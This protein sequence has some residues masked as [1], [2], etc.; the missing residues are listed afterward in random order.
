MAKAR[1]IPGLE[2]SMPY[3]EAAARTVAVRAREV[4]EHS[5]GVLDTGDIERVHAM[6]VATRRLRAV[7]EI[8]EPCFPRDELRPVLRE[9]KALADALGER[10][11]PDVELLA[12][13][14]FAASVGPDERA[15]V[16]VFIER[17]RAQQLA[18]NVSLAG[19]LE[20]A[21]RNDLHGRLGRLAGLARGRVRQQALEIPPPHPGAPDP[22]PDVVP[23]PLPRPVIEPEPPAPPEP[24]HAPAPEPVPELEPAS[25]E[26]VASEH[27]HG[28]GIVR[29]PQPAGVNED[30]GP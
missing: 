18:A 17:T 30:T 25:P 3:G 27:P 12:L 28:L 14:Q 8:Y 9:V 13:E 22:Q 21:E 29:G 23:E 2:G 15:G 16:E 5:D 11:D 10:R 24:E 4:E 6:R 20:A 1:D 7:L 19:A 26:P